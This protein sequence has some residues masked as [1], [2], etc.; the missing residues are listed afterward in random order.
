MRMAAQMRG[1][2]N[3]M[4][5]AEAGLVICEEAASFL[6]SVRSRYRAMPRMNLVIAN[7][8]PG[9]QT[10]GEQQM[11]DFMKKHGAADLVPWYTT[12][13]VAM[14]D[15][16]K[17]IPQ[18][19]VAQP[20]STW[21]NQRWRFALLWLSGATL[22]LTLILLLLA[23]LPSAGVWLLHCRQHREE[24]PWRAKDWLMLLIIGACC[25]FA[26]GWWFVDWQRAL[27]LE[28]ASAAGTFM[29]QDRLPQWAMNEARA[30]S[31]RF[32]FA[33][34]LGVGFV[35]LVR[36]ASLAGRLALPQPCMKMIARWHLQLSA[37]VALGLVTIYALLMV[38]LQAQLRMAGSELEARRQGEVKAMLRWARQK[39]LLPRASLPPR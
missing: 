27:A 37:R 3:P 35:I 24:V 11:I 39:K 8:S 32:A 10:A 6:P 17:I 7:P 38:P 13:L 21:W 18:F 33:L 22:Q 23:L 30:G 2:G 12:E 26:L 15:F 25:A 16:K 34:A 36:V 5:D 20:L 29:W 31:L 14:Q 1:E 9:A 4:D 28:A 19:S